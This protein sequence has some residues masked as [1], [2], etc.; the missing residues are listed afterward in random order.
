MRELITIQ[1]LRPDFDDISEEMKTK[2]IEQMAKNIAYQI[3][4]QENLRLLNENMQFWQQYFLK[5][6]VEDTVRRM[7]GE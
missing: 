7:N 2:L 6:E 4:T 1:L 5:W 3:Y